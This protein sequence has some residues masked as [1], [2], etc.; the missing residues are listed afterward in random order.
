MKKCWRCQQTK[1]LDDFGPERREPDG[2][3]RCCRMCKRERD[4]ERSLD[5]AVI[6]ARRE[7]NRRARLEGKWRARETAGARLRRPRYTVASAARQAVHLAV[8]DGRLTK[9]AICSECGGRE[10]RIEAHHHDYTKPLEV[11]WLCSVCHANAHRLARARR[12]GPGGA[13]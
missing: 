7:R 4:A 3:S 12:E 6:L 8:A 5:P 2:R 9:P 10:R 1:A 13:Q 11:V